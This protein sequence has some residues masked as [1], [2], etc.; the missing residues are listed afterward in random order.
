MKGPS[1]VEQ[2]LGRVSRISDVRTYNVDYDVYAVRPRGVRS[3]H[4]DYCTRIQSCG[5]DNDKED[6]DEARGAA[7][8]AGGGIH[9]PQ[10]ICDEAYMDDSETYYLR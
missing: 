7:E 10:L 9:H 3:D 5:L 4:C 1:W 8:A 6:R 2:L